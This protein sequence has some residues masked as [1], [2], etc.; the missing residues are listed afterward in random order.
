MERGLTRAGLWD[1]VKDRLQSSA[2]GLS[3][4]Q[5]QRLC[6]ARALMLNPSVLVLDEAVSALDVSV[7]ARFLDLLIDLQKDFNLAYLFVTH[8]MAEAFMLGDRV[9]LL[10]AGKLIQVGE[11]AEF[12]EHPS[13]PFVEAF[14]GRHLR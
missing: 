14:L 11:E 5:Q 3:G 12:P 10:D 7:Q 9:A 6:I 13:T 8:D 1:E 2:L 4:G